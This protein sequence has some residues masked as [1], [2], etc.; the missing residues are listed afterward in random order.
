G[1]GTSSATWSG[2]AAYVNYAINDQWRVSLRLEYED[3][4][5]GFLAGTGASE[6][7][8]EAT[9]TFGYDPTKNFEL[10]VEGR[11]DKAS[12]NFFFRTNP[13]LTGSQAAPQLADS[14]FEFALQ[15]VYKFGT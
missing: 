8:K 14:L 4:K 7:A 11:Y 15:G 12:G 13:A 9:L 10:R 2:A 1:A 6:N 3:D 5:D